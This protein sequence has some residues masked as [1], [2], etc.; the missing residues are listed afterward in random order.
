MFWNEEKKNT[1]FAKSRILCRFSTCVVNWSGLGRFGEGSES[2]LLQAESEWQPRQVKKK[3]KKRQ[4]E[5]GTVSM[6]LKDF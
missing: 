5:A 1:R 6:G 4:W 2:L 3:K